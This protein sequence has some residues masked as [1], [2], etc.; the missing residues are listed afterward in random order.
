MYLRYGYVRFIIVEESD[1]WYIVAR[2]IPKGHDTRIVV[3]IIAKR[4]TTTDPKYP[5]DIIAMSSESIRVISNIGWE[6]S[7]TAKQARYIEAAL[8]EM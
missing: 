2:K 7:V 5:D 4:R 8:A 3:Y 6:E 1:M